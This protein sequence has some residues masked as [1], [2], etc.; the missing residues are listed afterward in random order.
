ME[1]LKLSCQKPRADEKLT[2]DEANT[3]LQQI[4]G[5]GLVER[6]QVWHLERVFRFENFQQ[7][8]IFTNQVGVLAEAEDHHPAL[9]TEWGKVTVTFWTHYVKGLHMNDFI[10]AA[11]TDQLYTGGHGQ[12]P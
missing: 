11:K 8:L 7:S 6:E 9:L 2:Q 4:P 10:A 1:L 5:W 3:Y 12:T